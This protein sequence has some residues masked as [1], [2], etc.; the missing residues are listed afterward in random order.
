MLRGTEFLTVVFDIERQI[1]EVDIMGL[2]GI[3]LLLGA[4][5]LQ[6]EFDR[7]W[8][9]RSMTT[10]MRFTPIYG[11]KWLTMVVDEIGRASCRERV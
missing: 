8:V 9:L 4:V 10:V 7:K 5:P 2:E 1:F 11:I 6:G 3:H